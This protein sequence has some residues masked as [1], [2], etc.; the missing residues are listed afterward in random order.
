MGKYHIGGEEITVDS[1]FYLT[2]EQKEQ[3]WKEQREIEQ[4]FNSKEGVLL[5]YPPCKIYTQEFIK[6]FFKIFG[7]NFYYDYSPK[8]SVFGYRSISSFYTSYG[9]QQIDAW[10]SKKIREENIDVEDF[11]KRILTQPNLHPMIR[12]NLYYNLINLHKR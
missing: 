4:E 10:I 2:R 6:R 11:K 3:Y 8:Y 7:I 9:I 1:F 12:N 5:G